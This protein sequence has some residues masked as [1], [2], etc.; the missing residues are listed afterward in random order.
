MT[1]AVID[2]VKA[3]LIDS[4][5]AEFSQDVV[6]TWK[7]INDKG[8]QVTLQLYTSKIELQV[9]VVVIETRNPDFLTYLQS[10]VPTEI[11]PED[12]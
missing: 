1:P 3:R 10:M 8:E 6:P 11:L 2:K 12:I 9:G 4:K 7:W 5:K